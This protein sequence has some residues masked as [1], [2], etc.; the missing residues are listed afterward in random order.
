MKRYPP[1]V[2]AQHGQ[3]VAHTHH[4]SGAAVRPAPGE[5]PAPAPAAGRH[6][7]EELLAVLSYLGV[8]FFSFVPALVIYLAKGRS[9]G[10]LRYHAARAVNVSVAVI[11]FD[12]SAAIAGAVLSLDTARV[13]LTVIVP[14]ATV[15]WLT[16]VVFLVRAAVAA[17]RGVQ[18]ELPGWLSVRVLK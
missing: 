12:L 17:A 15:L 16:I 7:P 9:S 5:R 18:Y 11:L 13:A 1:E 14:L 2:R 4:E 3:P 8:I 6:E 10:Y